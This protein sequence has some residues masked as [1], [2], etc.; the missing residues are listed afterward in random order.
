MGYC[1]MHIEKIKSFQ[2]M[3][4]SYRHNYRIDVVPNANPMLKDQ[5]QELIS[6]NGR[7]YKDFFE[8]TRNKMKMHGVKQNIRKNAVL[9][10]DIVLTFSRGDREYI[11]MELWK[12]KNVEWLQENFNTDVTTPDGEIFR[13]DNVASVMLHDDEEGNIH[14]HAHITPIDDR[15]HL[16]A[17]FY[18]AGRA[19]INKLQ[20]SYA[21]AMQPLGLKRGLENS[22]AD[23]NSIKKFYTALNK[24]EQTILPPPREG[25]TI[26]EYYVR[27]NEIYQDAQR[28]YLDAVN[29]IKRENIEVRTKSL[30]E[31]NEIKK[32]YHK[33]EKEIKLFKQSFGEEELTHEHIR[34]VRKSAEKEKNFLDAVASYPDQEKA[35]AVMRSYQELINWQ[36]NLKK[37]RLKREKDAKHQK[38]LEK[39]ERMHAANP[40]NPFA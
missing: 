26:S 6:L 4:S 22:V 27:A 29:K 17:K 18:T 20:N 31:K 1:F 11:D 38:K 9:G 15:G 37:E 5:N 30:N 36:D 39:M 25:E 33:V 35:M 32:G 28:K 14:L 16:N 40:L 23:H 13:T 2:K 24:I 21:K 34:N 10:L 19:E 3:D 7:T 8:D 12:Q